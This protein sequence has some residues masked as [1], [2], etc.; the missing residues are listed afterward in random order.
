VTS[1]DSTVDT[2]DEP[3]Y[4]SEQDVLSDKKDNAT[5]RFFGDLGSRIRA[6]LPEKLEEYFRWVAGVGI[7][8]AEG[9]A[10]AH[11]RKVIH[12][13]IKPSNLIIDE[14][15][16]VW[17]ADFGLARR[18][19]DPGVTQ[20][21]TLIGTPRYMSPEQ[22]E[23]ARRPVDQRSDLYS[24]GATLYELLT[25]RPV[26][27]GKTPHDV[28]SQ[29]IAREPV[30]PRRMN[31]EIPK[32]L[33]TIVMKAMAK[34]PEDRYQTADQ[35]AED[36][37]RWLR[38]ETIK[39]RRIGPVGRTIRWCRRNPKIAAVS[40]A[41]ILVIL[42][43]SGIYY[44]SLTSER[45]RAQ[46][47]AERNRSEADIFQNL[48]LEDSGLLGNSSSDMIAQKVRN[49]WDL[50]KKPPTG[51][52]SA[53]ALHAVNL[54]RMIDITAEWG[55]GD[56][57][58]AI[59]LREELETEAVGLINRSIAAGDTSSFDT[60]NT[61]ILY[62]RHARVNPAQ[63]DIVSSLWRGK[64][65]LRRKKSLPGDRLLIQDLEGF[66]E[67]LENKGCQTLEEGRFPEAEAIFRELLE[68]RLEIHPPGSVWTYFPAI[69]KGF[70]GESLIRLNRYAEAEPFLI[71]SFRVLNSRDAR[72]RL[73]ALYEAWGKKAIA[74]EY[75][76][77]LW[78]KSVRE[79]GS[80]RKMGPLNMDLRSSC[81]FADRSVWIFSDWFVPG[82][83]PAGEAR[84]QNG[85]AWTKNLNASEGINL[86]MPA[87]K[88]DR[89][90]ELVP[91]TADEQAFNDSHE[92][93][94]VLLTGP[95]IADPK[96]KRALVVYKKTR[97]VPESL[98]HNHIGCSIAVWL[99]PDAAVSRPILR[100]GSEYP[101]I[102]FEA[103]E[104]DLGM[105]AVVHG[106][107]LYLY[108]SSC[109]GLDCGSIVARA[110]LSD[111]LDRS[112]WRFY[113]G[114][115]NWVKDWKLAT[116]VLYGAQELSVHWNEYLGK[117]LAVYTQAPFGHGV[118]IQI[119][120]RPEG[121]WSVSRLILDGVRPA[122]GQNNRQA[123]CHPE[124][125]RDNG[126]VEFVTYLHPT[127]ES[128]REIQLV[129]ITFK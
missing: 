94:W 14:K 47:E 5:G 95:V 20:S 6:G 69:A 112:A 17:I 80:I 85:W 125:A 10:H 75:Q 110:P 13:D 77:D 129:E 115:N 40:A 114:Q 97:T 53:L 15:G 120:D 23:A 33:S 3:L 46:L 9:L 78:V 118:T 92:E 111:V 31:S 127:G 65:A 89:D 1:S 71:E 122:E 93:Q 103:N 101:T 22:A 12:R 63:K 24:L 102:L 105:G 90:R 84:R 62:L 64:I 8:A 41:A 86:S 76:R 26:F 61:M 49:V 91:L 54:L 98:S 87:P 67:Y 57:T 7:Q 2:G 123:R 82:N 50:Y 121:P 44:T 18:I 51:N 56:K 35:L 60:L 109:Q 104:P 108:A 36:L 59:E 11:E 117:Y 81:Y 25:C 58:A 52:D 42:T 124:F 88:L 29:I 39:A 128:G 21:G 19:E 66:A 72:L 126:R 99:Y 16:V 100:P 43:V 38:M 96:R 55:S 116:H 113:S 45:D 73:I 107:Y 83:S 106:D 48:I 79:L 34:R 4:S 70:L 27:E 119:A 68:V 30:A 74:E 28:I 32:D 37:N